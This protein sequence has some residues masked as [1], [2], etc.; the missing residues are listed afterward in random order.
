MHQRFHPCNS[1]S[2]PSHTRICMHKHTGACI[3]RPVRAHA[4]T[5]MCMCTCI[6]MHAPACVCMHVHVPVCICM[7]MHAYACMYMHTHTEAYAAIIL[8][9]ISLVCAIRD[10]CLPRLF[11]NLE[12]PARL[13]NRHR[14]AARLY[15]RHNFTTCVSNTADL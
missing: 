13:F 4:C 9:S 8:R 1:M 12:F 14:S 10:V 2:T 7:C 11:H 15:N 6:H 3:G 5:C